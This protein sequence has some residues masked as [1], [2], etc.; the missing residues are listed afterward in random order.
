MFG[1]SFIASHGARA[2][3]LQLG[4]RSVQAPASTPVSF[5]PPTIPLH[6]TPASSPSP[7]LSSSSTNLTGKRKYEGDKTSTDPSLGSPPSVKWLDVKYGPAGSGHLSLEHAI[8][9]GSSLSSS[10]DDWVVMRK[11]KLNIVIMGHKNVGKSFLLNTL[12]SATYASPK[13]VKPSIGTHRQPPHRF[14]PLQ[15]L[16]IV[17]MPSTVIINGTTFPIYQTLPL[18][19][20][21]YNSIDWDRERENEMQAIYQMSQ[22]CMNMSVPPHLNDAHTFFLPQ[23]AYAFPLHRIVLSYSPIPDMFIS[24]MSEYELRQVLWILHQYEDA[25]SPPPVPTSPAASSTSSPSSSSYAYSSNGP[26][27]YRN[28]GSGSGGVSGGALPAAIPESRLEFLRY[29]YR[30]VVEGVSTV[31]PPTSEAPSR[32]SLQGVRSPEHI[33][34]RHEVTILLGKIIRFCGLG[35]EPV[36]IDRVYIRDK[37]REMNSKYGFV[38]KGVH[39]RLP[40]TVLNLASSAPEDPSRNAKKGREMPGA[41]PPQP[42][43][44]DSIEFVGKEIVILNDNHSY[45]TVRRTQL[46]ETINDADLLLV[47]VDKNGISNDLATLFTQSSFL[48][49]LNHQN[50]SQRRGTILFLEMGEVAK[51]DPTSKPMS[52]KDVVSAQLKR[53]YK[54]SKGVLGLSPVLDQALAN[55]Q[56][57]PLRPLLFSSLGLNPRAIPEPFIHTI[58]NSHSKLMTYTNIPYLIRLLAEGPTQL[59]RKAVL[60]HQKTPTTKRLEGPQ[61]NEDQPHKG[62]SVS[63]AISNLIDPMPSISISLS[64]APSHP[65]PS[66]ITIF[67]VSTPTPSSSLPSSTSSPLVPNVVAFSQTP[68]YHQHFHNYKMQPQVLGTSM[69]A[70]SPIPI[71]TD[72]LAST[73]QRNL[74]LSTAATSVVSSSGHPQ[75]SV[76]T[77]PPSFSKPS[78]G[79]PALNPHHIPTIGSVSA[80]LSASFRSKFE[81]LRSEL[82]DLVASPVAESMFLTQARESEQS[83]SREWEAWFRDRYMGSGEACSVMLDPKHRGICLGANM[84]VLFCGVLSGWI[85]TYWRDEIVGKLPFME[86]QILVYIRNLLV[87]YGKV[88]EAMHNVPADDRLHLNTFLQYCQG[89]AEREVHDALEG[90]QQVLLKTDT[91]RLARLASAEALTANLLLR[92]TSVTGLK[93]FHEL[94]TSAFHTVPFAAAGMIQRKLMDVLRGKGCEMINNLERRLE[95]VVRSLLGAPEQYKRMDHNVRTSFNQKMLSNLRFGRSGSRLVGSASPS[96]SRLQVAG[97]PTT[98]TDID[99]DVDVDPDTDMA[100]RDTSDH[101]P[102][103]PHGVASAPA[104]RP[105]RPPQAVSSLKDLCIQQ[106]CADIDRVSIRFGKILPEELSQSIITRLVADEQHFGHKRLNDTVLHRL[107]NRRMLSLDF[108]TCK[109]ISSSSCIEIAHMC[110]DLRRLNLAQCS[111]IATEGLVQI[112]LACKNLE[113][114]SIEGCYQVTDHGVL[115]LAHGCPSLRY[116]NLSGC[117]KITDF[118]VRSV[119]QSCKSLQILEARKC[120]QLTDAAF[121]GAFAAQGSDAARAGSTPDLR[122]AIANAVSLTRSSSSMAALSDASSLSSSPAMSSGIV[123]LGSESDDMVDEAPSSPLQVLDLLDCTRVTDAAVAAIA[124]SCPNLVVLKLSGRGVSD[125]GLGWIARSCPRLCVLELAGC[126]TITDAAA[127]QVASGCPMVHTLNLASCKALT[128]AAFV[129]PGENVPRLLWASLQHVDLTRCM[130]ITDLT[131]IAL[132]EKCRA[133]MQSLNLSWCEAVSDESLVRLAHCCPSL[134]AINLSKCKRVS[135]VGVVALAKSCAESLERVVLENCSVTDA[136]L[137]TLAS[138]C[139]NL[140]NLDCSQCDKVTDLGVT[141]ISQGCMNMQ[142]LSLDECNI[143]DVGVSALAA[144]A[145]GGEH[146]CFFLESIRLAYCRHLTDVSLRKLSIGCPN[147]TTLDLSYCNFNNQTPNEAMAPI[148]ECITAMGLRESLKRWPRLTTLRLRG[149]DGLTTESILDG[150]HPSLRVL[151]LSWCRNIEDQA[152]A[153]ISRQCP[154]LETCDIARCPK[155]TNNAVQELATR[156]SDLRQINVTGCKDVSSSLVQKLSAIGKM[157]YR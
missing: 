110:P 7:S 141:K 51:K 25:G 117:T 108:E 55:V 72:Q 138:H 67:P 34:L 128:D 63:A 126:E 20:A 2:E 40:S 59:P 19:A 99:V 78:S 154:A 22:Y 57:I 91:V 88:A 32:V 68:I 130:N 64:P 49:K 152:L 76:H 109:N 81:Q 47:A 89:Q 48:E 85:P 66:P 113:R 83:A 23:A 119:L 9:D 143:T 82:V 58:Y 97:P 95:Q 134:N 105:R 122:S 12:L 140:T 75:A 5:N 18:D 65:Q 107:L 94:V 133:R 28:G 118:A 149:M 30:N 127:Q 3:R 120:T 156:C 35:M 144:S 1:P 69:P 13:D 4:P 115:A 125:L 50:T 86:K 124:Q 84:I 43:V 42:E 104:Q 11:P 53:I 54:N 29:T 153:S 139:P 44:E 24:F 52:A 100:M 37:F 116:V 38:I 93:K 129:A 121:V 148:G 39:L 150:T 135:D 56:V 87:E 96:P 60:S 142:A 90:L 155:I 70:S 92:S 21:F 15:S 102:P 74:Q 10:L 31:P 71:N 157:I 79:S 8:R 136:S 123:S 26:G 46:V 77:P 33:P 41:N 112:G 151:N 131:I 16:P 45:S 101:P 80:Q 111:N 6:S 62:A 146:G 132:A 137:F 106:L 103:R 98:L 147:L 61:R 114:I 14:G 73:L 27:Y 17:P 145:D 36:M